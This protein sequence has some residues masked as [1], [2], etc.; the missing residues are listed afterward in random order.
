MLQVAVRLALA[1][2]LAGAAALKLADRRGARAA[3][4][5]F[6]VT[7]PRAQLAVWGFLV[8]AELGLAAGVAA[9]SALAA[10]GAAAL[11][12]AFAAALAWALA[13]GRA[14]APC[15]CLGARSRVTQA[16]L[17]RTLALAAVAAAIPSLPGGDPS[18]EGWLALG[19][20]VALAGVVGL[21]VAVA[22]LAREVGLLR[23]ALGPQAALEIAGEGPEVGGRTALVDRFAAGAPLGLAVFTSEG[24]HMCRSLEPAV[25]ALGRDPHVSL[26]IF[27]EARDAD[28]WRALDVPGAPYAVA[29]DPAGV[30]LAKGTF[31][32]PAQLEGILAAAERRAAAGVGG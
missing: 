17:A 12:A 26:E 27:E 13:T 11:L 18:T 21:G 23:M 24:C 9:G 32:T 25:E 3:L 14:G 30:V 15:G 2:V 31:N 28:V 16:A 8:V 10:Y 6:R 1:A 19:L 5:T 7:G 22:A 29:L 20:V 4:T